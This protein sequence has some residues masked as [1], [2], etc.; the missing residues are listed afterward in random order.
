MWLDPETTGLPVPSTKGAASVPSARQKPH[1]LRKRKN[2]ASK[3]HIC[4][5]LSKHGFDVREGVYTWVTKETCTHGDFVVPG[6]LPRALNPG[7]ENP[8]EDPS[9]RLGISKNIIITQQPPPKCHFTL[10]FCPPPRCAGC[11]QW[12]SAAWP[13]PEGGGGLQQMFTSGSPAATHRA[14][15]SLWLWLPQ[16]ISGGGLLAEVTKSFRMKI[17]TID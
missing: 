11:P 1:W 4:N 2:V 14:P 17:L 10:F 3:E 8:F 5:K 15:A 13:L 12:Q 6:R 7:V 9:Q 16:D